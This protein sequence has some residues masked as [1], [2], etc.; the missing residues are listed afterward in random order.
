[1][2]EKP[3]RRAEPILCKEMLNQIIFTGCYTLTL[4]ILF[5]RHEFFRSFFRSS[6]GDICFM[7]AFYALFIFAGI[8]NC[9]GARCER[10]WILSNI[11]KN[12]PFALIMLLIS[13]IQILMIYFGGTLFRTV[14][15]NA[16]ELFVVILLAFSVIPFE[17]IRRILYKLRRR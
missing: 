14:P 5:L 1:M 12:K 17:M 6:E 11:S 10:M 9:F 13:I 8:F 15:L 16:S 4:C 2:R 3:K 7:T